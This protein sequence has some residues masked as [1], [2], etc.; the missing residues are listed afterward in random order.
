MRAPSP[1]RVKP[2]GAFVMKK[3]LLLACSLLL[4]FSL[5]ACG[6][7]E[8]KVASILEDMADA[9]E[10]NK[11]DCK[12]M[13]EKLKSLADDNK[14]T[15]KN[16]YSE[17]S[18]RDKDGSTA[19]EKDA[20][21]ADCEKHHQAQWDMAD[22]ITRLD[23]AGERLRYY[24]NAFCPNNADIKAARSVLTQAREEALKATR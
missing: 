7:P 15:L 17:I 9:A 11:D 16:L 20:K 2:H 6:K 13:G 8:A 3:S 4:A 22:T 23:V 5:A 21:S 19:C 14:D 10:S 1:L 12:A 24:S 18:K